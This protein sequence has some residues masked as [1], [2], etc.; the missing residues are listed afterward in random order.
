MDVCKTSRRRP[1]RSIYIWAWIPS[2]LPSQAVPT[3]AAL[4]ALTGQSERE[5][6]G[7]EGLFRLNGTR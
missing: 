5:L 2:C 1:S 6:R 3:A 7:C 4:G